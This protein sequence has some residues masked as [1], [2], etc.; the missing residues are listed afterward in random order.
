MPVAPG[1]TILLC[2]FTTS[3]TRFPLRAAL[4]RRLLAQAAQA[5]RLKVTERTRWAQRKSGMDYA[6]LPAYPR[7]SGAKPVVPRRSDADQARRERRSDAFHTLFLLA[8]LLGPACY[9]Q[10][11]IQQWVVTNNPTAR[12]PQQPDFERA[13]KNYDMVMKGMTKV[14]VE[15]L[16]GPPANDANVPE[17]ADL[18]RLQDH[19]RFCVHPT[20]TELRKW[21]SP[22]GGKTWIFIYFHGGVVWDKWKQGF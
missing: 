18:K 8:M 17:L 5:T 16:L 7:T 9:L 20:Q 6:S 13:V 11:V 22:E 2:S 14:Q 21:Q 4:A 15:R 19:E 10:W 3:V 1:P 12:G